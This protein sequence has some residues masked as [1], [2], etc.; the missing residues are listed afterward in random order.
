LSKEDLTTDEMKNILLFETDFYE[1]IIWHWAAVRYTAD[2]L[3][4]I[5]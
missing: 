4:K 2:V 3:Q 1:H 5:L